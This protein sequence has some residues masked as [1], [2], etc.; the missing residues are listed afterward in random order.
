VAASVIILVPIDYPSVE[1]SAIDLIAARTDVSHTKS[2]RLAAA[3]TKA[4]RPTD[5]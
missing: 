3:C 2:G 5:T 1:R 4:S